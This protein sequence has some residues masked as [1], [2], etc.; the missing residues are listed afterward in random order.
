[1]TVQTPWQS[2]V[3]FVV[4]EKLKVLKAGSIYTMKTVNVFCKTVSLLH[5]HGLGKLQAAKRKHLTG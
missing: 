5:I 1:M 4:F 3:K 2:S